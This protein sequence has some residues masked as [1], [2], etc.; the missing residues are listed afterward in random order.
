MFAIYFQMHTVQL[1][2]EKEQEHGREERQPLHS[3][4]TASTIGNP[5]E[6]GSQTNVHGIDKIAEITYI[7][8]GI[9][10]TSHINFA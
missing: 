6:T 3:P 9:T 4:E 7:T 8:I 10:H 1:A 2:F 5:N